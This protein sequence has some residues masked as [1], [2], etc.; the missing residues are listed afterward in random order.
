MKRWLML[1][2]L[3]LLLA[4]CGDTKTESNAAPEFTLEDVNG[5]TVSLSDYKDEKVYIKF[6]A[7]WCSICLAGLEELNE[8]PNEAKDFKV[9][10]IVSPNFNNEKD[11]DAFVKWFKGLD[12]ADNFQVLLD[13]NGETAKKYGVRGYPTAAY[14]GTNGELIEVLPGHSSNEEIIKKF[15]NIK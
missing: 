7:S 9:L 6:W 15:E 10:T 5:Q 2:V 4:A 12:N 1:C 13:E 8:L 14:I 11:R 3:A